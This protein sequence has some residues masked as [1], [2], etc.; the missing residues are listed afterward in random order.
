MAFN[1]NAQIILSGPKNLNSIAKQISSQLGKATKIDLNIGGSKQMADIGKKLDAIN[2]NFG[3]LNSN[4]K[5]TRTS[6][7]ALN[8]SFSKSANSI[9]N[10]GRAQSKLAT[11]TG[12][13]N[14]ALKQQSG[15]LG[16]LTGRFGSVAKQAI[17]FGLISRPIYDVQ[18]AFSA[19]VKDA[20]SFEK[21]I[22][23]ISQVTG[24]SVNAL[25]GLKDEI[26]R[27]A[28]SLG[29]S[30]NQLAETSRIIAQ[31][32]RSAA[33]IQ[34]ILAALAKSTLA[35]TFGSITDTTEGL[36]AA[37]GQFQ[38]SASQSEAILGSLNQV[39]KQ[40]AVEAEDL[41]SVVRRTGGVFAQAA[42]DSKGTIQALQELTAIFTA[43]RS[44]T[45][46][47]AD[48]IAAG[49][50][51][52]FSRI[53]R[54]STISFLKQFGVD[55]E[56]A[57]G[58]FIGIFPAFDQ[59]STKLDALIKQGDA[60]TLS[61]IAE[62]LGG[63]R[64]IGKLLPA[65]AEFQKARD[66]FDAAQRGAVA[67][68]EGDVDK[69]LQT[70]S[71]RI[72]RVKQSFSELIRT[73]FESEGFQG[74]F[75]G[76][77]S[78]TDSI[79]QTI[80]SVVD[81]IE[82]ILPLLTGL[83]TLKLGQA[84]GGFLSGGGLGKIGS[85]ASTVTGQA[86]AQAAQ[87]NVQAT[88]Q[89]NQILTRINTQIA[90]LF[91]SIN[92]SSTQSVNQL[93]NLIQINN[94]GFNTLARTLA[95][96]PTT[97]PVG[98]F[99]G[100]RASG[101]SIPKFANGGPVYGPSHAAGGVIAE[102]EGGEY[103]LPRLNRGTEAG[104]VRR[105]LKRIT[106]VSPF[107][108]RAGASVR[109]KGLD[110]RTTLTVLKSTEA[111]A[112][113][114]A[115]LDPF[116]GAFLRPGDIRSTL[117]GQ[118][119]PAEVE[120]ELKKSPKF[121]STLKDFPPRSP[122]GSQVRKIIK[123]YTSKNK[124]KLT[125][126]SLTT[127]SSE[128]LEDQILKGV[129]GTIKAGSRQLQDELGIKG[130][131]NIALALKSANIDQVIGN[132]FESI[133]SFAGVPFNPSDPDPPNAPVDF[134]KGL[135]SKIARKFGLPAAVP[136]EAK[137]SF[138]EGNLS[139]FNQKIRKFNLDE[140]KQELDAVF[141]NLGTIKRA[142]GGEIPVRISNGE[143]VVTDPREVAARKGELQ[144]INKLSTG[145]FASGTI[146]RGPGTGTSDS[147]YTTLPQG[148]FVVNAAST[149]KY[150]GLRRGGGV[151]RFQGGGLSFGNNTATFK[152]QS[153]N[154]EQVQQG[155]SDLSGAAFTATFAI[156]SFVSS[157]ED[158][159]VTSG[160]LFNILLLVAPTVGQLASNFKGL[161]AGLQKFNKDLAF[162]GKRKTNEK[163]V[164]ILEPAGTAAARRKARGRFAKG[165]GV[166]LGLAAT[167]AGEKIGGTTGDTISGAGAGA[168][169]G[170][171]LG[172]IGAGVGALV[173][174]IAAL[175]SSIQ[176]AAFKKASEG[177]KFSLESS[178][179]STD[180]LQ[181]AI[182]DN[183]ATAEL[184]ASAFDKSGDVTTAAAGKIA[185][186]FSKATGG[187]LGGNEPGALGK[188]SGFFSASTEILLSAIENTSFEGMKKQAEKEL[189]EE[190]LFKSLFNIGTR[191]P[192]ASILNF[193]A[194]R[195]E[196]TSRKSDAAL[197]AAVD[198]L[199]KTGNQ[200]LQTLSTV[201]GGRGVNLGGVK[202][203]QDFRETLKDADFGDTEI[204]QTF[205]A[206][207][208]VIKGLIPE[209][210]AQIDGLKATG[211]IT[212]EQANLGK[213]LL[214]R[215]ASGETVDK[216]TGQSL[217][218]ILEDNF[219][220][221][222]DDANLTQQAFSALKASTIVQNLETKKLTKEINAFGIALGQ[223]NK[224]ISSAINNFN[225]S[226][227]RIKQIAEGGFASTRISDPF[228]N[229]S[230]ATP[231]E[232]QA[233][234]DKLADEFGVQ[235]SPLQKALVTFTNRQPEILKQ[236]A[237]NIAGGQGT[238]EGI[239]NAFTQVTGL[240]G[241]SLLSSPAFQT[242][243][244][245]LS[246]LGR[247]EGA[248]TVLKKLE[249]A[250]ATGDFSELSTEVSN[251]VQ[252]FSQLIQ[253]TN[254]LRQQFDANVD[255]EISLQR[256]ELSARLKNAKRIQSF[257]PFGQRNVFD[258]LNTQVGLASGSFG[259][260]GARTF[261]GVSDPDVL[262]ARREE[263]RARE[264]TLSADPARDEAANAELRDVRKELSANTD[265]LIL[266]KDDTSRLAKINQDLASIQAK[267]LADRQK[268]SRIATDEGAAEEFFS[269]FQ[270]INN[271]LSGRAIT[272]EQS[273][274]IASMSTEELADNIQAMT[275]VSREEALKQAEG[276][277]ANTAREQAQ[278]VLEKQGVTEDSAEGQAIIKRFQTAFTQRGQTAKEVK[279]TS[280]GN[281]II[282]SQNEIELK[283]ATENT[284]NALNDLNASFKTLQDQIDAAVL[285][286][287]N[288]N[289]NI[290][291]N[292]NQPGGQPGGQGNQGGVASSTPSVPDTVAITSTN[293][294]SVNV[295]GMDTANETFK[296]EVYGSVAARFDSMR[297]DSNGRPQDPSLQES[298]GQLGASPSTF[299][300]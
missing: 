125:A 224:D 13:T 192:F 268:I 196:V 93:S 116:A 263:L 184:L 92:S 251:M 83:G 245:N 274:Q 236:A 219:S 173:G 41:I 126:G 34:P 32:G 124:F 43:V 275:G 242:V 188:I 235:V 52:I 237:Q 132:I 261:G 40:F 88:N 272:L 95:T 12:R 106:T 264:S 241:D 101:G 231:Q 69:G 198:T 154:Q 213:R 38:L 223:L 289:N 48:T 68:L 227:D 79:L 18:R 165:A 140:A 291:Q 90:N 148:A 228:E 85:A 282:D 25:S 130:A 257:D 169:A 5:S 58:R 207:D 72:D 119:D 76:L 203:R 234:F 285:R 84:F 102:L 97:V 55:L 166:G 17:A 66:A 218:N 71:N 254:A 131:T 60:L 178:K 183:T 152:N 51:T 75:K 255:F 179:K 217:V 23:K 201:L 167:F 109:G 27:L 107:D 286:F 238:A 67:G 96:R 151:K 47:S 28:T 42:G 33:E 248:A 265:A 82:P 195:T 54:R 226:F 232:L 35:P 146:A 4:L 240:G 210:Q 262:L 269:E 250:L 182:I 158:G 290:P 6:I 292:N 105:E 59:L 244:D 133:L 86:T 211:K 298:A 121:K 279:L 260:I 45:R 37:L 155:L 134:P 277:Q 3:K 113:R 295:M 296:N 168:A 21:E 153:Q 100:R 233:G 30:A 24:A 276:A 9:N 258:D 147:I 19:A 74:A 267:R 57:Q 197:T 170:A 137:S 46:E 26:N 160:E 139:T 221:V 181:K 108:P 246:E 270:A 156:Q 103:V 31:T 80:T 208:D 185:A 110:D 259:G 225:Q 174:G 150:L 287:Q 11:Q 127:P 253:S 104:N 215:I 10:V 194:A 14:T 8:S 89:T 191:S 220:G 61:S 190:G 209:Y 230:S 70:I 175:E 206:L 284:E 256:K 141:A 2:K 293:D 249:N 136:T 171:L 157:I 49:L 149:K 189:K 29:T 144:R 199:N 120:T 7:S 239:K 62:E 122:V 118:N 180:T 16:N 273:A 87:Q 164:P 280:Q 252:G 177:L 44:T 112:R 186:D 162:F 202:G 129:V 229:V 247:D 299:V 98:G 297:T 204:K 159:K 143:M 65:I 123:T 172:P 99:G 15:L 1:I 288:L 271:I 135:R 163:G 94:T 216:N 138:T 281:T 283:L 214:F 77:L 187:F 39:S 294:V 78:T 222:I 266:L 81:T 200:Q 193:D 117:I 278:R 63:I 22:V 20:V 50:R 145:G 111:A 205:A 161:S 91:S 128:K 142:G 56:D 36:I 64:Q 176:E 73:L 243:I 300:T 114:A 212:E 115:D 53:Q